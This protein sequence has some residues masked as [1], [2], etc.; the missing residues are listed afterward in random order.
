MFDVSGKIFHAISAHECAVVRN[1]MC[2]PMTFG[3]HVIVIS[4]TEKH[5]EKMH[6][7]EPAVEV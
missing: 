3:F 6:V 2:M 5:S 1:S 4:G 7:G